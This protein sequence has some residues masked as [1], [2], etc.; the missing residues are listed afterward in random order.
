M[1]NS[2]KPKEVLVKELQ[3]LRSRIDELER[4][5]AQGSTG[6]PQAGKSLQDG[7]NHYHTLI[8]EMLN[9]FALHE[10]ICD[11]RGVPCDYRFLEVNPA[12]EK[13]TGLDSKNIV[14]KTVLEVLPKTERV[15]IESY[16]YFNLSY[17]KT[18]L[19]GTIQ[20]V[21]YGINNANQ[22]CHYSSLVE[23]KK[24]GD[25]HFAF[26]DSNI[27]RHNIFSRT[28]KI[29]RRNTSVNPLSTK[30]AYFDN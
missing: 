8:N 4:E 14:G 1:N 5:I 10:I 7:E 17:I 12:F 25:V 15:W 30:F 9:G 21:T 16:G 19:D 22:T 27:S 3:T 20:N 23:D 18:A 28:N 26:A 24:T 6:N 2:E 29:R 13:M 11:E